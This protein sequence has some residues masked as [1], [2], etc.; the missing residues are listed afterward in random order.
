MRVRFQK[1]KRLR[2]PL[3]DHS[4]PSAQEADSFAGNQIGFALFSSQ[5]VAG[6]N[7]PL[8]L[9]VAVQSGKVV[10]AEIGEQDAEKSDDAKDGDSFTAP[11]PDHP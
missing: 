8:D 1:R 9:A 3:D 5:G 7:F 11:A 4:W 6:G 2:A 10:D